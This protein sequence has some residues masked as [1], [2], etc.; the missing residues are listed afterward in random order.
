MLLD[1]ADPLEQRQAEKLKEEEPQNTFAVIADEVRAK[2]VTE[3]KSGPT[4]DRLDRLHLIAK[5][6]FPDRS[7]TSITAPE[8]LTELRK[9]EGQG[10]L[11]TAARLRASISEVFRY[12]IATGRAETDPTPG[13]KGAIASPVVTHQ[14]SI[15]EPKAFG[16]LLRAIDGYQGEITTKIALKLLA[17]TFVRPGELRKA[18]WSEFDFDRKIWTVTA[19]HTK[20]RREHLVPLS[21]QALALLRE[22]KLHT[23]GKQFLFPAMGNEARPMSENTMNAALHRMGFT[24]EMV[25]HGFRASAEFDAERI[26]R[27]KSRRDRSPDAAR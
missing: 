14:P 17:L 16:G 8:I 18:E 9:L 22:L 3:R 6:A 7:I 11:E 27:L 5:R 10:H 21:A 25:S 26:G 1:G 12:A 2:K 4:L 20:K 24:G 15:I 19:D 13:L 23:S